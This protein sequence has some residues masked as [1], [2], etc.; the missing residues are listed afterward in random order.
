MPP[1]YANGHISATGDPIYF[2]FGSMVRFSGTAD[3]TAHLLFRKI[4]GP[5][6]R[7]FAKLLW[8]AL[9]NIPCILT[10]IRIFLVLGNARRNT[11]E[12]ST[13]RSSVGIVHY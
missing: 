9:V 5:R 3:Q 4:G 1:T 7:L 13:L 2:M 11:T 10:N 8:S 6:C 12:I